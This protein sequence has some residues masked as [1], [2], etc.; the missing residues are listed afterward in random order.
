MIFLS[1]VYTI[2]G[3]DNQNLTR[4]LRRSLDGEVLILR[5]R[6]II[7]SQRAESLFWIQPFN[8]LYL[9]AKKLIGTQW[10]TSQNHCKKLGAGFYRL[11]CYHNRK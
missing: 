4:E 5:E 2:S 8:L 6:E 11:H 1:H 7:K 3:Y 9:L 10:L